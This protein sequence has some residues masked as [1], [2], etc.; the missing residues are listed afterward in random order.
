[1]FAKVFSQIYDSSIVEN[2]D[3]RFTFMDL[4]V[5]ADQNGVVDMTHEAIAR[6]TNRPIELIRKTISELE[7]GDPRSRS[8]KFKGARIKRLDSHRDWGWMIVNYARFRKI[9]SGEQRREKTK[10][11]VEKFRNKRSPRPPESTEGK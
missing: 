3:L 10:A 4:L 1:V 6:R 8:P 9:A 2:A 5:L 11:R 7:E